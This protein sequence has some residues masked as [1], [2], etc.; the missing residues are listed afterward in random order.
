VTKIEK[1]ITRDTKALLPVHLFGLPCDMDAILALARK[2]NLKVIEDCAQAFGAE[3]EGKKASSLGDL[4]CLS[5]FP[6]KN[7]GAYGD[8]GMVVTNNPE[9]AEK[10]KMLRNHGSATKYFYSMHGFNSRLDT[11]QAAIVRAK[12]KYIDK[13]IDQRIDNAKYYNQLLSGTLDIITPYIPTQAKHAFNYYTIRIRGNRSVLQQHL[14][15]NGIAS[16]IYYPLCLHLQEVYKEL[17]CKKGDFPI[18]E[19]AQDEALSLPMYPELKKTQIE[20]ITRVIKRAL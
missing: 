1:K 11:M 7:L 16:A 8:A 4:G 19:E 17:G 12:L 2:N 6:G 15:E 9:V 18:A 20:E 10:L 14:K 3:Y 5:F 13:W